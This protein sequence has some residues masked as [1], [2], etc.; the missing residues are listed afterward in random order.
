MTRRAGVL[1]PVFALWGARD[2]PAA[3]ARAFIDWLV[4]AR[5]SVWQVLPIG[6]TGADGSPYWLRSD[7]A[8]HAAL[9]DGC[10]LAPGELAAWCERE[11]EWAHDYALAGA[12][13][14][15]HGGRP[16]QAWPAPLRDREPAALAAARARHAGAIARVLA[17]QCL[18][19]RGWSELRAYANARGVALFG[20]LPIYLAPD[21]VE[22]WV[23][24]REFQLGDDG[25]PLALAGVPPDYFATDGQLWGNPLYDWEAMA[26]N[27]YRFWRA[28]VRRALARF[29]LLRLDHFRGLVGYWR[30]PA[31]AATAREGEWRPAG[32]RALL[33]AL[34][35]DAGAP[36]LVAEDLG[37]ITPDVEALRLEFRLP[38]M[39]VLQFAFDGSPDNPYLPHRHTRDCVVYTG[40]H[41]NDTT[42]GWYRSLDA[43]TR[44]RVAYQLHAQDMPDALIH[45]A[46]ASVAD[47][48]VIPVADLL[49]LDS[50]A[51][52]N[53]PG[54]T[55]GNWQWRLPDGALTDGLARQY[56][57][58]NRAF[59]RALL[60]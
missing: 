40:T 2:G 21:S 22:T 18:A 53:L 3:A 6:P 46:L 41:D 7:H 42:L 16:W 15:E 56:A 31:G 14:A 59:G 17:E 29:D 26:Q 32:G 35:G 38:G 20:D 47:L 50:A 43:A 12:L 57:R 28:R 9:A 10:E 27:D 5:F 36:V 23:H 58:A 51:R 39:K 37:I 44:E 30:V 55:A 54:T 19:A 48:A 52:I 8:T 4:E 1:L 45:A 33:R 24:R 49:A 11:G 13:T 25:R 60:G 34:T